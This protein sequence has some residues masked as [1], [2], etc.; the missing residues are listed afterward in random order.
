MY[1]DERGYRGLPKAAEKA[2]Q[3]PSELELQ[4]AEKQRLSRAY[5][6]W[7]RTWAR[8]QIATEPRLIAFRRYLKSVGPADGDELIDSIRTSWLPA[9]P[10]DVRL[11][12]LR[13]V[14]AR[15]QRVRLLMGEEPLDDPWPTETNVYF[16]AR[17]ILYAG[18]RG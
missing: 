17:D 10:V 15:C 5:R 6:A 9:A 13:Q 18:G 4:Q 8:E 12:A 11:F 7:K 14:D 1:A 16:R 3:G 2:A